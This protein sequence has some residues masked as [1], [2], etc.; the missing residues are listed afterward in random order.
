[1]LKLYLSVTVNWPGGWFK[2]DCRGWMQSVGEFT[3]IWSLRYAWW[4]WRCPIHSM[5]RLADFA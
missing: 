1:M 5:Y 3:N 4:L 2:G